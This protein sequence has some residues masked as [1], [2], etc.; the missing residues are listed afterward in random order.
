MHSLWP[1]CWRQRG[2]SATEWLRPCFPGGAVDLHRRR[3]QQIF[4][5]W[6]LPEGDDTICPIDD[7]VVLFPN[8]T[9]SQ[10]SVRLSILA[11]GQSSSDTGERVSPARAR[12][13]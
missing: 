6:H 10:A 4:R 13:L 1:I 7:D 3:Y 12:F 9:V 11:A 2:P 8:S 5:G